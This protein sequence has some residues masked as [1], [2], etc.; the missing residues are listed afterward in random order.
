MKTVIALGKVDVKLVTGIL[1]D[2]LRFIENP[3]DNDLLLAQGAIVRANYTVDKVVFDKMPNLQVLARTGVGTERVDLEVAK[4]RN[5]PVVITPGS[6]T[7]AVAE[8]ALALMLHLSKRLSPLTKLVS[9]GQWSERDNF[10][11]GDIDGATVGII[12]YGRIGRRLAQILDVMGAEVLAFDPFA[13]IPEVNRVA[14]LNE[15]L[16]AS[17]FVSLHVPL[18]DDNHHLIND[19][20]LSLL[21][22]GAI[23]V[24][25][26]RG[27]LIN[28]DD[29][30]DALKTGLLGGL[31]LDVFDEEP[32][33]H[34]PIF[35]HAN[36]VL[37][38]H[39]M[40]LSAKAAAQTFVDA[41][42]GIRDVL[43][44]RTPRATA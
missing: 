13:E 43:E 44:G 8:G 3:S 1:G 37:T 34:H 15:L 9:S 25:C 12:G 33:V 32:P 10:P 23:V 30:L 29:A 7:N 21:K 16:A 14:H 27:P 18:T 40:G 11:L 35:D 24:N 19:E 28:L 36:V 17:D 6:N 2:Q 39:V 42:Q 31:G 22:P 41:A 5:I 20:S 38:P 26:S 4:S